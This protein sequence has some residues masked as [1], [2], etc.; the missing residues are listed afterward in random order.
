MKKSTTLIALAFLAA[1]GLLLASGCKKKPPTTTEESRPPVEAP[2]SAPST[3]VTPPPA[4]QTDTD[5]T[6][7]VMNASIEE[8]NRA[9]HLR[10][11]F[12]DYDQA[13]LRADARETLAANAEWL[14]RFGGMQILIEGHADERGTSAYNLALGERRANA[15]KDYL[16]SLG[17]DSSRVRTVSYGKERPQCGQQTEDCWQRNRRDNFV[18]TAK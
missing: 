2:S 14:K 18:I 11:I 5:P 7:A 12:F 16:A 4:P 13:D 1:A 6:A 15:A 8:L 10:E 3:R 9:G 17:V